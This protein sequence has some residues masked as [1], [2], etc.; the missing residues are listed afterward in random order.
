MVPITQVTVWKQELYPGQV[1][2]PF[3][4]CIL[5]KKGVSYIRWKSQHVRCAVRESEDHWEKLLET[6]GYGSVRHP[7]CT[8]VN[9]RFPYSFVGILHHSSTSHHSLLLGIYHYQPS[10]TIILNDYQPLSTISII[11]KQCVAII[12][13]V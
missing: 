12:N 1:G 2:S 3:R 7:W 4:P 10:L 11:I 6:H 9:R 13:H 8:I 5:L